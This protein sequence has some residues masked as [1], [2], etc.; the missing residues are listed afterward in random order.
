M[1]PIKKAIFALLFAYAK[2][3]DKWVGEVEHEYEM[4][5]RRNV[6]RKRG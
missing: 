4:N 3:W 1:H 2:Q 6:L 5:R